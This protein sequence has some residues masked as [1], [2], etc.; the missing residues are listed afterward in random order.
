MVNFVHFY[1]PILRLVDLDSLCNNGVINYSW[2][3][4]K[5]LNFDK[6]KI[7][8][9]WKLEWF[10]DVSINTILLQKKTKDKKICII[11]TKGPFMKIMLLNEV[12]KHV[13][14][15]PNFDI[16]RLLTHFRF[17]NIHIIQ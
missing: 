10:W 5:T 9:I 15:K 8:K 11:K 2:T 1:N 3:L 4:K 14:F 13:L 17:F 7:N 6:H 12:V 16:E